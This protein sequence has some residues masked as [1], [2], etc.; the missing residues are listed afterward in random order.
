MGKNA[1]RGHF[2]FLQT[3]FSVA[4]IFFELRL[5]SL[6]LCDF[7]VAATRVTKTLSAEK[8]AIKLEG[9]PKCLAIGEAFWG[10]FYSR[11]FAKECF[12]FQ[13]KHSDSMRHFGGNRCLTNLERST[14]K[15]RHASV[16]ARTPT[17]KRFPSHELRGWQR[18]GVVETGVKSG[19]KNYKNHELR[20]KS[21]VA[22]FDTVQLNLVVCMCW[23]HPY[24][25]HRAT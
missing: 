14:R 20:Q 10:A 9:P 23:G 18:T 25:H 3:V 15:P 5:E 11:V 7:E 19:L 2:G 16:L 8:S 12:I 21:C 4:V 24:A 22:A 13:E 6:A 17:R 1:R